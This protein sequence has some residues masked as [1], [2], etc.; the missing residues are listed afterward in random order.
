[1]PPQPPPLRLDKHTYGFGGIIGVTS[2][3][4][5]NAES[6]FVIDGE[7]PANL[8]WITGSAR[9]NGSVVAKNCKIGG[10]FTAIDEADESTKVIPFTDSEFHNYIYGSGV[11]TD[12]TG[13]ENYDGCTLLTAEPTL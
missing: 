12:W 13:T 6:Y 10:G 1:M 7:T 4:I 11:N 2:H 5:E 9:A 3:S 8:G